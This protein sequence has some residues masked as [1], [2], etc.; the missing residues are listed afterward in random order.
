MLVKNNEAT[1]PI[2][3]DDRLK[4]NF[5][6]SLCADD[7]FNNIRD[8]VLPMEA[9]TIFVLTS[10]GVYNSFESGEAY[11][12]FI[13]TVCGNTVSNELNIE[14]QDFLPKLS[15]NGSGDDV[16]LAILY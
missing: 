11:I 10:D 15:E 12:D 7:A 1:F 2:E 8:K 5:T 6:T 14:L 3:T 16:S 9:G 13:K 4:F